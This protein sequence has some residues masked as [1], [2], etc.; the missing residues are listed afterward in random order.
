M[1]IADIQARQGKIEV[2]C[3]VVS[4]GD[5]RE[6]QKFGRTGRVCTAKVKDDSGEIDLTLWNEEV[7]KVN[8]GDK[9]KITNGYCNEF[10]GNRQLTAGRF[11]KM[12]VVK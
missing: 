4:K 3:K 7:D 2:E 5:A 6:F 11:G 12:E 8:V 9:I 1:K 10:Q